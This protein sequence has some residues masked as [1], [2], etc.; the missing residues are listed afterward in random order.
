MSE[1]I[2]QFPLSG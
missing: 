2:V 1:K